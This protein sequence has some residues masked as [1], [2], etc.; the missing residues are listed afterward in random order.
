MPPSLQRRLNRQRDDYERR[1]RELIA[2]LR[3][4]PG[5]DRSLLRLMLLGALN[6]TRVWYRPGKLLPVDIARHWIGQ[7]LR[8]HA[9]V[10]R[11]RA[12]G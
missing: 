1:F 5:I 6:W 4:R 9:S 7:V 2:A 11:P 10:S 8:E 12:R 3:I